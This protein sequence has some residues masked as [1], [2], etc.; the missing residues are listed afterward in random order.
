MTAAS[1]TDKVSDGVCKLHRSHSLFLRGQRVKGVHRSPHV[2]RK[3]KSHVLFLGWGLGVAAVPPLPF[4]G[5]DQECG[6]HHTGSEHAGTKGAACLSAWS[7]A[8]NQREHVPRAER[9]REKRAQEGVCKRRKLQATTHL[10]NGKL[11]RSFFFF[12]SEVALYLVT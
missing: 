5:P 12:F 11:C 10:Y 1:A 2:G 4:L 3:C 9:Q 7:R 6:C 8:T